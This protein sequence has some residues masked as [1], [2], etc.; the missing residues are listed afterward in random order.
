MEQF[1]LGIF[2][3]QLAKLIVGFRKE[4]VNA[5]L[6][7]GKGEITNVSLNC[8]IL[9]ESIAKVSPFFELESVR[10][11]KLS[12]NV[13]SWTNLKKAPLCVV[14]EDIHAVIVEPLR[15][16][17][18]DQ[19]RSM[20][21]ISRHEYKE[22]IKSTKQRGSYS[23]LDRILDNLKIE[24]RSVNISFQ[25]RGKFKT[26]Q[27]GPWTPPSLQIVIRHV[28]Y[29]MVNEFGNPASPDDCWRHNTCQ[30]RPHEQKLRIFKSMDMV[31]DGGLKAHD[32]LQTSIIQGAKIEL[33]II[34][35]KRVHDAAI[36][37]I[38]ADMNVNQVEVL[39]NAADISTFAHAVA[40]FKYCFAKDRGFQDPLLGGLSN[41]T[42]T[43]SGDVRIK[44]AESSSSI[45]LD[46]SEVVTKEFDDE[47]SD[48]EY[49]DDDDRPK[50][51]DNVAIGDFGVSG[52]EA[53]MKSVTTDNDQTEMTASKWDIDDTTVFS[54]SIHSEKSTATLPRTLRDR[55]VIIFP[56]GIVIHES[57]SVSLSI[58]NCTVRCTYADKNAPE[59]SFVKAS[60]KGLVAE[61]IWPKSTGE[62]GLH[63][64]ISMSYISMQELFGDRIRF[65][66]VGG[67][68]HDL[69]VWPVERS[70]PCVAEILSDENFPI[71]IDRCIQPDSLRFRHTF[72]AQAVGIKSTV[73]YVDNVASPDQESVMVLNEVGLDQ[74]EIS[75]DMESW[76]RTLCLLMNETGGG[77]DPRWNTGDWSDLLTTEML[78]HP[79]QPLN[80]VDHVQETIDT[81]LDANKMMSSDLFNVT[82][83]IRNVNVRVPA[84]L[85]KDVRSCDIVMKF[86]EL[87]LVISSALPRTFLIGKL[88]STGS[89]DDRDGASLIEFPNDPSDIC[90][91]L[92]RTE[93]LCIRQE[94]TMTAGRV[95]TFR[96]QISVKD[97]SLN[98]VPAI[99]F[100]NHAK[101]QEL[102]AP[103]EF[104][105]VACFEGEPPESAE[106]NLM[107]LVLF[108]SVQIH[109]MAINCDFDLMSGAASTSIHHVRLVQNTV[110]NITKLFSNVEIKT[111]GTDKAKR[112]SKVSND[113]KVY[114]TTSRN[115]T[116]RRQFQKSRET[117]GLTLSLSAQLAEVSVSLWRQNVPM[118]SQFR[119]SEQENCTFPMEGSVI[120]LLQLIKL[121]LIAT[122]VG[123]EA[124]F[125]NKDRRVV[126][127]CCLGNMKI[128]VCDFDKECSLY[129]LCKQAQRG[130]KNE[131]LAIS[132]E[133]FM[134]DPVFE[135][136]M[137]ELVLIGRPSLLGTALSD[138]ISVRVEERVG[139]TREMS[140]SVHIGCGAAIYLHVQEVETTIFLV[141]EA[142][143]LPTG[144]IH[145]L[146]NKQSPVFDQESTFPI[147]S[148]GE[149]LSSFAARPTKKN[150]EQAHNTIKRH[151]LP[152]YG[153][154]MITSLILSRLPGNISTFLNR[155]SV[156]E[157]FVLVPRKPRD[158]SS[159]SLPWY[160]LFLTEA[161]S[162]TGF[163]AKQN[164]TEHSMDQII[165]VKAHRKSTWDELFVERSTGLHQ[166]ISM[167]Q[168]VH[169]AEPI[170]F[171]KLTHT[172][173]P[174]FT[175]QGKYLGSKFDF[176]LGD[177]TLT[178]LDIRNL[179]D[180][181]CTVTQL[182]DRTEATRK[183]VEGLLAAL[184][185]ER[186]TKNDCSS[187]KAPLDRVTTTEV[188]DVEGSFGATKAYLNQ[189]SFLIA[190]HEQSVRLV[191][192][193]QQKRVEALELQVFSKE[194]ARLAA[195]ALV[196]SQAAGWLRIGGSHIHGQRTSTVA[197]MWRYFVVL[198]KSLMILYAAPGMLTP[199]HIVSLQGARLHVLTG[200]RK[201]SDVRNGFAIVENTGKARLFIA[202]NG[203]EY[204]SWLKE[205]HIAT[206]TYSEQRNDG[207]VDAGLDE[208]FPVS[209]GE[210]YPSSLPGQ[211]EFKRIPTRIRVRT[212]SLDMEPSTHVDTEHT[213]RRPAEK[214]RA[215]FSNL[216]AAAKSKLAVARENRKRTKSDN[217]S[218]CDD[219]VKSHGVMCP[220]KFGIEDIVPLSPILHTKSSADHSTPLEVIAASEE[221]GENDGQENAAGAQLENQEPPSNNDENNIS[222][223][224]RGSHVGKRFASLRSSAKNRVSGA[225]QAAM[226]KT[227]AVAEQRKNQKELQLEDVDGR[228]QSQAGDTAEGGNKRRLG[229][230]KNRLGGVTLS[231][232]KRLDKTD[233]SIP[234]LATDSWDTAAS[235]QPKA[236]DD[237]DSPF[238]NAVEQTRDVVTWGD[239]QREIPITNLSSVVEIVNEDVGT[240]PAVVE[241]SV[242]QE[243]EDEESTGSG[244]ARPRFGARVKNLGDSIRSR[245]GLSPKVIPQ[246]H[247]E[248][249]GRFSI[250]GRFTKQNGLEDFGADFEE[251]TIR[252]VNVGD[253]HQIFGEPCLPIPGIPLEKI[254][255]AF[256]VQVVPYIFQPGEAVPSYNNL[257]PGSRKGPAEIRSVEHSFFDKVKVPENQLSTDG[258][259]CTTFTLPQ[260]GFK[261]ARITN[262]FLL[263]REMRSSRSV[264]TIFCTFTDILSLYTSISDSVAVIGPMASPSGLNEIRDAALEMKDDLVTALGLS[265]LDYVKVTGSLLGGL[266]G[267]SK[268]FERLPAFCEYECEI[269]T[270]FLNSTLNCPLPEEARRAVT[271]FLRIE[272][273]E[274]PGCLAPPK[275]P[276]NDAMEEIVK[277]ATG[278]ML[279]GSETI[280]A[281]TS[282]VQ[283]E[284]LRAEAKERL[285]QRAA[286]AMT[287]QQK[288]QQSL[289]HQPSAL[290]YLEPLLPSIITDG[291]RKS[292]HEALILVMAERDEAHARMVAASVM[293]VHEVEQERKKVA[294]LVEKLMIA[295]ALAA[296]FTNH[297]IAGFV[298]P[299]QNNNTERDKARKESEENLKKLSDRM[300]QNTDIELIAL[301]EQLS[302]EIASKTSKSLEILRLHECRKVEK[303]LDLAEKQ[304][305]QAELKRVKEALVVQ[306][307]KLEE[308]RHDTKVW[309]EAYD[310][311]E[312][313]LQILP[314]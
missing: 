79:S 225:V 298:N 152:D 223:S 218:G 165:H 192:S 313:H 42:K 234:V 123:I 8:S 312:G 78:V 209:E 118:I 263:N 104:T 274:L 12:F 127:K 133:G 98:L 277:N 248:E 235:E 259:E 208:D 205:L 306:Q 26:R 162:L 187:K 122:E 116:T 137:I 151:C 96:T 57:V 115:V 83:R 257:G 173:I 232:T 243:K 251:T 121:H 139:K 159:G 73:S 237:V 194:R 3:E 196:A 77:F 31:I 289:S 72:P 38:Q 179:T 65:L 114:A 129:R 249:R 272:D 290:P 6:L 247:E 246:N 10:I 302:G 67:L 112:F 294:I 163:F 128:D 258:K 74:F 99:P 97:L 278:S 178:V 264:K 30:G 9:N 124:F 94:R 88:G 157:L 195:L 93:D 191:M 219:G 132:E 2:Q 85:S 212:P 244:K 119:A 273:Y 140:S 36:L 164:E 75:L 256:I 215:S 285:S 102:V 21:Q 55:P 107:K 207:Q 17:P 314:M 143:L 307:V 37:S 206:T 81:F 254:G 11:S 52:I 106:S 270:E 204:D 154:K 25:P 180:F 148:I 265:T 229:G 181:Y 142:L 145:N 213:T 53:I 171:G 309:K 135:P 291:L 40:G 146:T 110:A 226:E 89:G 14:I 156:N 41:I 160:G 210:E 54:S 95:S 189:L 266:I 56:T 150:P 70:S 240:L 86:A 239:A 184:K 279:T 190:Q 69:P 66:M 261:I 13:T 33:Q 49:D 39:M 253:S 80:L 167:V 147:G 170:N 231:M 134:H 50:E 228:Q 15:F 82:G 188:P 84:A 68:Q 304:A 58:H 16:I 311:L 202:L 287:S 282:A 176:S 182:V 238:G 103:F 250:R 101:P 111:P 172:I 44:L 168:S 153:D 100:C 117:G 305:L 22:T 59:N 29:Q 300:L 35:Q 105:L 109:R 310:E 61:I 71:F 255:S 284:V 260:N 186:I 4:Q 293:H 221:L 155:V 242:L 91:E 174:A 20:K 236:V 175:V 224:V 62:K 297:D 269:L 200:G 183:R 131:H 169:A 296:S 24:I 47:G 301:C 113:S 177:S 288:V 211:H 280:L 48:E 268:Q 276:A 1:V 141:V 292:L 60:V 198:R 230:L 108:L 283:T 23:L 286:N 275:P 149:F 130:D 76:C 32:K 295:Q 185:G 43:D 299:F 158:E 233:D 64:Q 138:D 227:K 267:A 120:P 166:T 51:Y 214:V 222:T 63:L 136:S 216:T 5:N 252:G 125:R 197:N 45:S 27:T 126:L 271:S 217:E 46:Q 193:Q 161:V 92:E 34:F 28:L 303:E 19:R 220:S 199:L 144:M 241:S 7:N 245:R 308:A 18:K 203:S 90:Y 262:N 87:M 281:L 201:R